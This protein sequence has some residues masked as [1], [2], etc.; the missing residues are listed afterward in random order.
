MLPLIL[1]LGYVKH[2]REGS[3]RSRRDG[4]STVA[5]VVA[6]AVARAVARVWQGLWSQSMAFPL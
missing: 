3:L 6:R 5:R 2:N 4:Y 1:L